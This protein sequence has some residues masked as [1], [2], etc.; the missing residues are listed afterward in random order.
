MKDLDIQTST[1][2]LCPI[3]V[4]ILCCI[5]IHSDIH[6]R[7]FARKLH[8]SQASV[9][10]TICCNKNARPWI[11]SGDL[12]HDRYLPADVSKNANR[13]YAFI[14]LKSISH[15]YIFASMLQVSSNCHTWGARFFVAFPRNSRDS[16]ALSEP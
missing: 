16:R 15:V 5:S 6:W 10:A 7:F 14:N 3:I 1:P 9:T 13:G 4:S 2:S 8:L 11:R 12:S